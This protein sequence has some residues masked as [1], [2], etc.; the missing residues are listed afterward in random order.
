M[1][2][3]NLVEGL[4]NAFGEKNNIPIW[5]ARSF[6]PRWDYVA[7]SKAR[8]EE[9]TWRISIDDRFCLVLECHEFPDHLV[10]ELI[11]LANGLRNRLHE[12]GS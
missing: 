7:G 5:L 3:S 9:P 12:M 4:L 11:N 8:G 10:G 2:I 1:S 6:G